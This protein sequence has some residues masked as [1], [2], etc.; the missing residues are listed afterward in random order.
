MQPSTSCASTRSWSYY[1]AFHPLLPSSLINCSRP[2]WEGGEQRVGQQRRG[3]HVL[4]S[5]WSPARHTSPPSKECI[6]LHQGRGSTLN[7]LLLPVNKHSLLIVSC[8]PITARHQLSHRTRA[9]QRW[10]VKNCSPLPYSW[11]RGVKNQTSGV[12][13]HLCTNLWW[14]GRGVG[15]RWFICDSAE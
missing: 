15:G 1:T 11:K 2:Q 3:Q 13:L 12:V 9:T 5:G 4:G 10:E 7:V 8:F 14:K 6:F